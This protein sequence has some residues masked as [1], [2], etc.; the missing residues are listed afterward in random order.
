MRKVIV[1]LMSLFMAMSLVACGK[2]TG[3]NTGNNPSVD[4]TDK[5]L[6]VIIYGDTEADVVYR[7]EKIP[8]G[9]ISIYLDGTPYVLLYADIGDGLSANVADST[10]G[11]IYGAIPYEI[12]DKE[13][14]FHADMS[15]YDGFSFDAVTSYSEIIDYDGNGGGLI[16]YQVADVVS[17]TEKKDVSEIVATTPTE[18]SCDIEKWIGHYQNTLANPNKPDELILNLAFGGPSYAFEIYPAYSYM[19][20]VN[21]GGGVDNS[22][23][24]NPEEVKKQA[25]GSWSISLPTNAGYDAVFTMNEDGSIDV[26]VT[27][28]GDANTTYEGH[29]VK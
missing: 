17:H 27:T 29:F 8:Q 23:S 1:A 25:N 15:G 3:I 19:N 9:S 20:M 4:V 22:G 10:E 26:K 28:S 21:T 13:F 14:V 7:L 2:N 18:E 24:F 12:S 5:P 11:I 6:S 16:T